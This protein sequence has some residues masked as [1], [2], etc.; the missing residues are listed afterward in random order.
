[1][2]KESTSYRLAEAS[3]LL[4][5][6]IVDLIK[7]IQEGKLPYTVQQGQTPHLVFTEKALLRYRGYSSIEP[8]ITEGLETIRKATKLPIRS[9]AVLEER[10]KGYGVTHPGEVIAVQDQNCF[11]SF[12]APQERLYARPGLVAAITQDFIVSQQDAL[13]KLKKTHYTLEEAIQYYR[14]KRSQVG[15]SEYQTKTGARLFLRAHRKEYKIGRFFGLTVVE[16]KPFRQYVKKILLPFS[17][18]Y[19]SM[20]N[21]ARRLKQEFPELRKT[22]YHLKVQLTKWAREGK[23]PAQR[24]LDPVD[25]RYRYYICQNDLE[26][27]IQQTIAERERA[28]QARANRHYNRQRYSDTLRLI[29][30]LRREVVR[31]FHI[32]LPKKVFL[33]RP[34]GNY[35]AVGYDQDDNQENDSQEDGKQEENYGNQAGF[36]A[37]A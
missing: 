7:A 20:D 25:Y 27:M 6:N 5:V 4:H 28:E 13:Q 11:D 12:Y 10:I 32:G 34:K 2:K 26:T 23:I 15:Y 18:D 35:A 1:M 21:A 30:S 24:I 36:T 29:K 33:S 22:A 9:R 16:K 3:Q 37:I 14:E 17:K 31:T 19:L 8:A